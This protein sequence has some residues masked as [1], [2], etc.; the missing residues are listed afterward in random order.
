MEIAQCAGHVVA[1]AESG[2]AT[3]ADVRR[4]RAA[5]FDAFLVGEHLMRAPD[6]G[7]A[8]AALLRDAS[9]EA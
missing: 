8:L 4:L 7:L 5:G 3:G 2:I 6:P 1:V 9:P